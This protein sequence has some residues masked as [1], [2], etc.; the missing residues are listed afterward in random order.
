MNKDIELIDHCINIEY[1]NK[2]LHLE[3]LVSGYTGFAKVEIST[4]FQK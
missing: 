3:N 4:H 1:Y 2:P